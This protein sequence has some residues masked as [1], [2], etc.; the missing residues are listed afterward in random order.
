MMKEITVVMPVY[1]VED[2][3]FYVENGVCY[4]YFRQGE[5]TYNAAGSFRIKL[6]EYQ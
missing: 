2:Y 3:G 1:K 6:A 4:L 5:T